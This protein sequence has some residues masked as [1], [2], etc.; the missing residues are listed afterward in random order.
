MLKTLANYTQS[1]RAVEGTISYDG[2]SPAELRKHYAAEAAYLPE[3]EYTSS[4]PV[5]RSCPNFYA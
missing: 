4:M 5:W 3:G 1:Y 2:L